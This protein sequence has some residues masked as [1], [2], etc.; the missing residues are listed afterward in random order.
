ME[1]SEI[2]QCA[3]SVAVKVRPDHDPNCKTP[4]DLMHRLHPKLIKSG[5]PRMGCWHQ[6]CFLFLKESRGDI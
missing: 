2:M 3:A 5:I 6:Y 4:L 1:A